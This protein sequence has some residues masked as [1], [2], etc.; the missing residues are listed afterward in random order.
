MY[1]I[2]LLNLRSG[3]KFSVLTLSYVNTAL[4]Q[5]AFRVYKCYII[6]VFLCKNDS[7][8]MHGHNRAMDS[9][10]NRFIVT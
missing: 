2:T 8:I 9:S 5:S 10:I 7:T 4:S 3:G 1:N 6:N